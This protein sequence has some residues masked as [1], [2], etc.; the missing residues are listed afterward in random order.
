MSGRPRFDHPQRRGNQAMAVAMLVAIG[1]ITYFSFHP[2][3]PFSSPYELNAVVRDSNQLRGGAPVRI[4]GVEAGKVTGM[5]AGPAGTTIVHMQID[6]GVLP[7]HSDAT[8]RIRPRIF[9]EG[10]YYVEVHPGTPDGKALDSGGTIPLPQTA[11]PVE[12]ADLLTTFDSPIRGSLR[13]GLKELDT[14]LAG[15]GAEGLREVAPELAPT[16]RDLAIVA[17][18]ARGKEPDEVSR[19]VSYG[20][21]LTAALARSPGALR[22]LVTNFR[23]T[24]DALAARDAEL[25]GTVTELD[26]LMRSA[27][28]GLQALDAALPVTRRVVSGARPALRVAPVSLRRT[29]AGLATTFVD[30]PTLITR[31]ASLFPAAKPLT[32]CLQSHILPNLKSVVPDGDLSSGRPVWQDFAHSLVGLASATQNFD[33]NGYRTRYEFGA[34]PDGIATPDLPGVGPLVGSTKGPL[35]S[36]PLPLA[37]HKTPALRTDVPCTTQKL[38]SLETPVGDAGLAGGGTP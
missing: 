36:R 10:G 34:G 14:G 17:Q 32:D 11:T 24:V 13:G 12:F 15:G 4:A 35:H 30:L 1:L 9:L 37:D 25:A 20:S 23:G 31:M 3:L 8:L 2:A 27:P 33:G 38:P 21:R 29:V 7:I 16:L 19:I 6:D 28:A 26:A 5:G 22:G 18:A